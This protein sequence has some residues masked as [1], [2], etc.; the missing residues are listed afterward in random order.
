MKL[1]SRF[2]FLIIVVATIS[3]AQ[4][5]TE[6]KAKAKG[7][8]SAEGQASNDSTAKKTKG[9][10]PKLTEKDKRAYAFGVEL[11]LDVARQG[12][13]LNRDL[14]MQGIKDAFSDGKFLMTVEDMNSTLAVMQKEEHEKMVAAVKA[15]AEKSKKE[16][17]AFLATNKAKDGVITLPSGLQYRVLKAADGKKPGPD[18]KVVC[19][20]R[21]TLLDGT[22][23]DSSYK[24]NEASTFPL[25]GVIKGWA[26]ALQLMPV[27]SK[28]QI[29]V[30]SDMAYG[31]RGDG[32]SIGPNAALIFEVELLS[33]QNKA[34]NQSSP[35]GT[36]TKPQGSL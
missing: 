36:A 6:N 35:Q 30:P 27:G 28:W 18:D 10:T 31:E 1:V 33:I 29:F 16:G 12:M 5:T 22:E 24:R 3:V 15:F 4:S 26:Q 7:A 34:E 13:E 14:L 17:E 8:A 9:E 23:I 19:N 11:G 32:R 20:Y 2:T 25:K 21:G